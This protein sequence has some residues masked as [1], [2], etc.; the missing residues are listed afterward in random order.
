[1][2]ITRRQNKNMNVENPLQKLY[3][4]QKFNPLQKIL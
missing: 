4:L 2:K 3:P 1:M